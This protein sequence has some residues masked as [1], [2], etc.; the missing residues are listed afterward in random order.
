MSTSGKV[1]FFDIIFL[2]IIFIITLLLL[3]ELYDICTYIYF[4]LFLIEEM[5]MTRNG[6][7]DDFAISLP[8]PH[9]NMQ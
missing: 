2:I 9:A 3:I 5:N 1:L 4:D 8:L 7:W 6:L